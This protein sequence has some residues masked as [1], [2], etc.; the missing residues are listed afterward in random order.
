MGI[1]LCTSRPDLCCGCGACAGVCPRGAISMQYSA[2]GFLYPCID[3]SKCIQCGLCLKS[4]D[5]KQF[6]P[7]GRKPQCYAVRHKDPK[8]LATSRSGGVF[9]ALCS[10]VIA[11]QG[12]VFGCELDEQLH[13]VHRYQE[14]YE[15]CKGFKGSKYVQSDLK[16]TFAECAA[17]LRDGRM[18]LYSGTGCQVHGLLRY[19][20]AVKAP[21]EKLVTVDIVCHGTP[22]PGVW[23]TYVRLLEK[24]ESGRIASVD[25]R[26]KG[27]FGW[28]ENIETYRFFDGRTI[29]ARN[30]T[31]GFYR[32]I[33]LRD[34][35]HCCKYTT[36]ERNTDYTIG[37]YWGVDK[38]APELDDDRGCSL[39]LIHSEKGSSIFEEICTE[40]H[41][42][43]T[44]LCTSMQPQL[45][46]STWKGWDRELFLRMYRSDPQ[47]AVKIWFFPSAM[48][49]AVLKVERIGKKLLKKLFK[50]VLRR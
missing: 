47:L 38:N 34:S 20:S 45:S 14:S 15:G 5:F 49:N 10:Y 26:N 43:R 19:L 17:F 1:D 2:E 25:F 9:M 21:L 32:H 28:A 39:V 36:T 7:T 11:R 29:H 4:C 6:L 3:N 41:Y 48:T 42:R 37:D 46:K 8:E 24:R 50:K 13:A 44:D 40:I 35:C 27:Q 23:E 12:V 31:D 18:V 30:W 22:S 33:M 16:N